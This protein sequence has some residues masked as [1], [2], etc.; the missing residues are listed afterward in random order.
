MFRGCFRPW[1]GV[2]VRCWGGRVGSRLQPGPAVPPAALVLCGDKGDPCPNGSETPSAFVPHSSA[3][4]LS[5]RR[6]IIF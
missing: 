6:I 3:E 5:D 2:L 4:L 1:I